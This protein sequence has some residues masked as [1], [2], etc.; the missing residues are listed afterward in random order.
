MQKL[1]PKPIPHHVAIIMD[2]NR[3]WAKKHFLQTF[4][5]HKKGS[6]NIEEICEA[7]IFY[8]VKKLTLYA[9]STENW[10]R[11]QNE[12][13]YLR[14]LMAGYLE[15]KSLQ[16][17]IDNKIIIKIIGAP[18]NFGDEIMQK[19]HAAEQRSALQNQSS[20]QLF[21]NIALSYGSKTEITQAVKAI[22]SQN[23]QITSQNISTALQ[24]PE[25]VALLIRTGG[26]FR[27][28]NFLLWQCAYAELFF[29]KTLWPNF[30]RKNFASAIK[31]FQNQ[32]RNF[33][34]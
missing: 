22:Q 31:F 20:P 5:G 28:S 3:R 21:L 1:T 11:Q 9:F 29:T 33:G 19:I 17:L 8:R 4:E 15:S 7:A 6:Q 32:K 18:Q 12:I 13:E 2:G 26:D 34:C 25:D 16:K 23:L 24:E 10:S 30:N 27:L 14:Q